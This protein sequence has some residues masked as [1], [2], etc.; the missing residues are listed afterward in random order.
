MENEK[1]EYA[2]ARTQDTIVVKAPRG[3]KARWVHLSQKRAVKLNAW[4]IEHVERS[5]SMSDERDTRS[6]RD[7]PCRT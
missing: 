7:C 3:T 6:Q 1:S 5:L 4:I 2:T